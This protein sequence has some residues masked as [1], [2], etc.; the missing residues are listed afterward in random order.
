MRVN[1]VSENGLPQIREVP[2]GADPKTYKYGILIGPP[3]LSDLSLSNKQIRELTKELVKLDIGDYN[4]TRGRRNEI[5]DALKRVVG[6]K[7]KELL[8]Q[9]LTIYQRSIFEE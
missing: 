1:Y 5:L 3:D 4:D 7:D 9:V 8:R 2:D 6:R